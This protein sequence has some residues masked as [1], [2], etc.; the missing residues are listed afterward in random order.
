M[1]RTLIVA[2]ALTALALAGCSGGESEETKVQKA[3]MAFFGD[4]PNVFL[5]PLNSDFECGIQ[6]GKAPEQG[7]TP[8]PDTHGTCRWDVVRQ[9]DSW[10]ATF[11]ESWACSDF[12]LEKSG[13]ASCSGA[14]GS[15][16]WEW[17][18][19][20]DLKVVPIKDSGNYAPDM[21]Q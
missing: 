2:L 12:S 4:N 3:A 10:Q 11:S 16:A 6:R 21:P 13:Y 7:A 15:H 18:V 20:Q 8:Y 5:P 19:D 9:G 14:Q 1:T 17:S